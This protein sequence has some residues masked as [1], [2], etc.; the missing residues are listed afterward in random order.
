MISC[1]IL[2]FVDVL[3]LPL[4]DWA[5]PETLQLT[6]TD[7]K[8]YTITADTLYYA[9]NSDHEEFKFSYALALGASS[10]NTFHGTICGQRI[11]YKSSLLAVNKAAYEAKTSAKHWF[12][13]AAE[14]PQVLIVIKSNR[15]KDN[16]NFC[17]MAQSICF[18]SIV[19][20][21]SH[22]GKWLASSSNT[23]IAHY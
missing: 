20:H 22:W 11:S 10:G 4:D 14:W 7:K 18:R 15:D 5:L 21:G 19:S 23:S 12:V 6:R 16:G 13:N 1:C 8:E 17:A 3:F 2:C 9:T